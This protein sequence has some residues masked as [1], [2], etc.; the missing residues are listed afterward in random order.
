[1]PGMD[2]VS[3]TRQIRQRYPGVQ[4]IV[5]TSL[6]EENLVQGA[7]QAGALGYLLQKCNRSGTG[8]RPYAWP[9]PE[10]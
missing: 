3:A 1:M 5:L 2:G 8:A 9:M 10:G 6:R 4:V 7:I